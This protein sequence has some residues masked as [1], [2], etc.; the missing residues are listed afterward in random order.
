M[1]PVSSTESAPRPQDL[2]E[3]GLAASTASDCVVVVTVSSSANLRWANNTLTTNGEMQGVEV[4]VVSLRGDR[5]ASVSG[6]VGTVAEVERLVAAADAASETASRA[7]DAAPLVTGDAAAEWDEPPGRTSV[8]VYAEV[9]P[10]LGEAFSRAEGS[11]RV[12]YGFVNHEVDTTYLGS[13]TGLRLRHEQPTGHY[14]FTGKPADL[15]ASAWVGGA[16]RDFTDVDPLA[17]DDE[18]VRRLGWS[19]RRVDLS[20]GR[21]DTVLPPT[22][23]AD[24][25]IYTYWSMGA[26]EALD[27]QTAFGRPGGGTRL[28]ESMA[29]DGV[30]LW[31][32]PR[33]A[34]LGASPFHVA[35]TSGS[36]VSVFDNGLPLSATDWIRGG[37]V[38]S[39]LQSRRT[40]SLTGQPPTPVI[41]NL[42]LDVAGGSGST[43]DL[44]RGVDRGVLVTCLWYIRMVDDQ[45]LLLTGLT[46]DGTYLVEGGEVVGMANNFRFNESPLSLLRRFSEAGESV[47]A[48][49]REWGDDYFSRTR[50]PALRIPDFAMSSV[51]QAL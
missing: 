44:V 47:S 9:A 16:T 19:R 2:V 7:E 13:S 45:R 4:T 33:A 37:R 14:G 40:A 49:S 51:S 29:H 42:V 30:H 23:V 41:D 35:R 12:H 3:R 24:L 11:D 31:S 22:S 10:R 15:T 46:R 27:G 38:T 39:L 48:F 21:Y 5:S 17:V 25:M 6:S 26:R 50:M 18:L 1:S 20:A 8:G 43:D 28:G 32:D 34:G 36:S